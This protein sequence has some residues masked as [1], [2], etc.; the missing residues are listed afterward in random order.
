M[1][2]YLNL[3]FHVGSARIVTERVHKF[4]ERIRPNHPHK[5]FDWHHITQLMYTIFDI[6]GFFPH[7]PVP[8]LLLLVRGVTQMIS[9]RTPDLIYF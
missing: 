5:V 4:N 7:A 6:K 3:G 9:A 1:I 8:I 2:R